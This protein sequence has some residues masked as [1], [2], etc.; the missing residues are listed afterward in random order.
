MK[1]SLLFLSAIAVFATIAFPQTYPPTFDAPVTLFDY[2]SDGSCPDFNPGTSPNKWLVNMV[3]DSLDKDGLPVRSDS[4]LY[5]YEIGKW[6]RP[7]KQGNDFDRPVY[8]AGGRSL[9]SLA[10][11]PYDTSYKNVVIQQNLTF[12][13]IP[14]SQGQY[15][16]QSGMFVPLDNFGFGA[17]SNTLSYSGTPINR[18]MNPHNYSFT[19]HLRRAFK[20]SPRQSLSFQGDDDCWIF[21]N[22]RLVLDIGGIHNVTSGQ[23]V[24]NNGMA[25]VWCGMFGSTDTTLAPLKTAVNLGLISGATATLDVFY[26]ERQAVGSDIGITSDIISAPGVLLPPQSTFAMSVAP[27]LDTISASDS[28]SMAITVLDDTGK[29]HPE[30]ASLAAWTLA[31]SGT[32]GSLK[33]GTGSSNVFHGVDAYKW[34]S[35]VATLA[36][37]ADPGRMFV[38][39]VKVYVKPGTADHLSIEGTS[40]STISPN[41]D[42]RLG[43]FILP[44]TIIKD[45]VYAMLRDHFGNFVGHAASVAWVSRMVSVVTVAPALVNLEEGE[46]TRVSTGND[47]AYVVAS[48][49]A[50]KDSVQVILR[51]VT[52]TYLT[53]SQVRIGVLGSDDIDSLQMRAGQDTTLFA[54]GLR[55]DGSGI[56]DTVP[57]GWWTSSAG[58]SFDNSPPARATSWTLSP[59]AA[60]TGRIVIGFSSDNHSLFDSIAVIVT[61]ATGLSLQSGARSLPRLSVIIPG[62]G[63]RVFLLPSDVAQ[64]KLSLALYSMAGRVVFA[65]KGIDAEKPVSLAS[66]LQP[67]IYIVKIRAG[68]RLLAKERFA[69]VR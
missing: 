58:L 67:G 48:Q 68:E 32:R 66:S 39:T 53:Y 27:R 56:W 33:S 3:K 30:L 42:D 13:Y 2:H 69:I 8:A 65:Q 49:A 35:I 47:S 43:G 20:Y 57:A 9:Q 21:I 16:F 17:D 11:V 10:T 22:G 28:I 14:G 44:G 55:S 18:T 34:Y 40:D 29:T 26:C 51:S 41:A 37:P 45:T 6:F 64:S 1:N 62:Y 50:M 15:Q 5:S 31:P 7:W 38:D 36:D 19:M 4:L 12:T 46:I 54:R 61:A 63:S 59:A 23:F 52:F 24:L 60:G 25:Y